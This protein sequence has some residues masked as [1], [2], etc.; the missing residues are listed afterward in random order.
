MGVKNY[1]VPQ[2]EVIEMDLQSVLCQSTGNT[3]DFT[4][5]DNYGESDWD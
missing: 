3:E 5:G 2:A 4:L 1:K